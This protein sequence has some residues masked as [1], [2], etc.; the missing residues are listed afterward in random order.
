MSS[1]GASPS[2]RRYVAYGFC[3]VA[4]TRALISTLGERSLAPLP[5]AVP[6]LNFVTVTVV[7]EGL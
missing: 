1:Y 3:L 4:R 2:V 6:D 7:C 5:I